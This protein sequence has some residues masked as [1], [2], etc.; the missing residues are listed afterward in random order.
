VAT[1][2]DAYV[3]LHPETKDFPKE[4][5]SSLK[6]GLIG[7][8]KGI[9]IAAGAVFAAAVAVGISSVKAARDLGETQSAV[10]V[11]FG[12][13]SKAV[14]EFGATADRAFGQSQN[15]ALNAANTFATFGKSAGL[16]GQALVG[17][18]TKMVG[19]AGD[20]AS[21][22]NTSP[23]EAIMAIGAALR[24]ESEP[25]RRYGVLLDDATLRQ[26]AVRLGI[27]KT[28]KTAL[29][30]QQRVLAAQSAI[31]KQ[32]S[33]AQGDFARTSGGLANQQRIAAAQ[34]ENLKV[35][36]G[37]GLL[38]VVTKVA[39]LFNRQLIPILNDLWTKHGPAVTKAF[40]QITLGALAFISTLSGEGTTGASG[41]VGMME[42]LAQWIRNLVQ[43]FR[44]GDAGSKGFVG[45]IKTIGAQIKELFSGFKAG[46]TKSLSTSLSSA[47]DSGK[48]L[49]PVFAEFIKQLP[50][51]SDVLKVGATVLKFFADN[52]DTLIK[53]L[54]LLVGAVIAYK[55]AQLAANVAA[56]LSVPVK[57][58][59]VV[60]NR[61]LVKSN[62][63]LIASRAALTVQ[64]AIGTGV[65]AAN[66]GAES[67]G[68]LARGRAIA[69]MVAQ[70][71]AAVAVRTAT[72]VWT[73][74]Q[75]LLNVALTANPIGLVIV[76]IAALVAVVVIIATKTTWFQTIWR[77]A[78]G[79]IKAAALAVANWF[80]GTA[81]PGFKRA[82]DLLVAGIRFLVSIWQAQFNLARTIV[83]TV[84]NAV[85][86]F[87]RGRIDA[88][89]ATVRTVV[90]VVTAVR[91]AFDAARAAVVDRLNAAVAVVRGLPGRILGALGD[92]GGL[93]RHAGGRIIQGLI[94]G[95]QAGFDRVRSML[96]RLTS[97]LPDWKGPVARDRNILFGPGRN[98]IDGLG[99]GMRSRIPSIR[100]LLGDMTADIGATGTRAGA[101]ATGA[102]RGR[103]AA[104][105]TARGWTDE[106]LDRLI[107]AI[108]RVAPGVGK[109]LNG[110]ATGMR[111]LAR[112]R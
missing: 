99:A 16:S 64:T 38:P 5:E 105:G 3:T 74:A 60:V 71:V 14:L 77:V 9:G 106:Q 73:A 18:S 95:I 20:L 58:A 68:I 21:F 31:L 75:W 51:L 78:W 92:L 90:A 37:T 27:I 13:S 10:N 49:I 2:A 59:E 87:V 57:I 62:R 36:I 53:I 104:G 56:L 97:L 23:E 88:I 89:I 6:R 44:E 108:E 47:A 48:K 25:I 32:T 43:A 33:D 109:E 11:I 112:A 98:I 42:R 22:K 52:T 65:T 40:S 69:S 70:R 26:E 15:Q 29:T 39:I 19:L 79:A 61:Q 107:A 72:L 12:K 82:W 24:G 91:N 96:G 103:A 93:L 7:V 63:E 28:T 80:T 54:P 35:R 66:T 84:F 86:A 85:V 1:L 94:D 30:P 81:V 45:V 76:A 101:P 102:R 4:T 34:I 67:A 46:D 8:M 83:M 100:D 50:T 55:V 17:F 111:Q 41:F 110:A